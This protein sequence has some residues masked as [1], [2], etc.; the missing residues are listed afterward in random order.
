VERRKRR[1]KEVAG[2]NRAE[3]GRLIAR[4]G[5][6]SYGWRRPPQCGAKY[7]AETNFRVGGASADVEGRKI[8]SSMMSRARFMT[9][10]RQRFRIRT[11]RKS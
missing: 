2:C 1:R 5:E 9:P 7:L 8:K 11:S 4:F 10:L 3:A 6:N